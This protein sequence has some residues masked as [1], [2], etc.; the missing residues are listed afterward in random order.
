MHLG[1]GG[2]WE[3]LT[4]D[5]SMLKKKEISML[6]DSLCRRKTEL[7]HLLQVFF[8]SQYEMLET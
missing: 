6:R 5:F 1:E 8:S 2:A 4:R 3:S 7:C